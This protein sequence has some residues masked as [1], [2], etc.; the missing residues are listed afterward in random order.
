M[1]MLSSKAIVKI[2]SLSLSSNV[3]V[4]TL[5]ARGIEKSPFVYAIVKT[6]YISL[7]LYLSLSLSLSAR[8]AKKKKNILSW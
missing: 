7:S 8:A 3:T 6:L 2:H 1:K 5:Y 4:K